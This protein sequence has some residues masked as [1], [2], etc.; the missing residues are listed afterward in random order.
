M[1]DRFPYDMRSREALVELIRRTFDSTVTVDNV[2]FED[3]FFSPTPT[4]PGR[5]F[6]EMVNKRNGHKT[7]YV[8]RRL[9]LRK[10]VGDDSV[11]RM[12]G[13]PSPYT[14]ALEINRSRNMLFGA[15]DISFSTT[16]IDIGDKMTVDYRVEALSGSYAYFGNVDVILEILNISPFAR[17][18]ENGSL[19]LNET[20]VVRELEHA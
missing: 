20:G 13:R 1:N 4:E 14:V 19:R 9:D 3:M 5:T 17:L 8:Y 15:D 11:F 7:W 12:I 16:L 6:I 18:L 10:V 2:T